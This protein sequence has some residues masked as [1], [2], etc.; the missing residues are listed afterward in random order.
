V[1]SAQEHHVQD[2]EERS[3]RQESA[4]HVDPNR[5]PRPDRTPAAERQ[6]PGG[7]PGDPG[8]APAPDDA[9][10]EHGS[11]NAERAKKREEGTLE[12]GSELPG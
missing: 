2:D 6:H 9:E 5:P 8:A 7:N 11:T 1:V 3:E 12:D 10:E 4:E